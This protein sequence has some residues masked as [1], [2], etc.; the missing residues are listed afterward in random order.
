MLF[1]IRKLKRN[2]AGASN[3]IL[4]RK[5]GVISGSVGIGLNILLF[6]GKLTIALI[7]GS[8]AIIADAFNNLSD[9]GSAVV[10]IAGFKLSGKKPD[11]QHPF[12]HGR[13]EYITGF[14]VS[15]III[16]MGFELALNSFEKIRNPL[17]VSG[18]TLTLVILFTSVAVKLY[19]ALYNYKLCKIFDSAAL[20]ATAIDSLSDAVATSAVILTL[21]IS[22]YTGVQLDGYAGLLVSAFILYSGIIAA[23]ET[24]APLLGMP[25]KPEFVEEVERIVMSHPPIVGMHDLVVHDYGPGRVMLSLHAEVP[26]E[27]NVFDAHCAI[28]DLENKLADKLGC[29]AVIHFDPLDVND[30]ELKRLKEIVTNIVRSIDGRLEIH[31]FRYVPGQTHTNLLFDV[32]VPYSFEIDDDLLRHEICG[33]VCEEIPNHNCV[34]KFDRSMVI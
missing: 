19:M 3:P 26:S 10:T 13:F 1:L 18:T 23:K 7:S 22:K 34:M 20:K 9:A 33:K 17:Q 32:V 28:D 8:A 15:V 24:L 4:R 16:V 31:D 2:S 29:E 5:Y 6:A 21:Y 14:V 27:I 12:G 30:A 11:P 25:P